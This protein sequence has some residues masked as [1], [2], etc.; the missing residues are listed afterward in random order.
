MERRGGVARRRT[1]TTWRMDPDAWN[2][3]QLAG[4]AAEV[5]FD[6]TLPQQPPAPLA[7]ATPAG[8]AAREALAQKLI[9][10]DILRF[11]TLP[12]RSPFLANFLVGAAAQPLSLAML[13]AP[14]PGRNVGIAVGPAINLFGLSRPL[15]DAAAGAGNVLV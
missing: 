13:H 7:D 4:N 2:R 3:L 9:D 14:G 10:T 8:T 6:P 11:T 15:A 12:D 1:T 5:R